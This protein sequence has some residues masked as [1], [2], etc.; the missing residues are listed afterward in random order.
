MY[1]VKRRLYEKFVCKNVGEIGYRS[2][3]DTD[4]LWVSALS[5][6]QTPRYVYVG[7]NNLIENVNLNEHLSFLH[8]NLE[9][10]KLV[11]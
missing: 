6:T 9:K 8:Y 11:D 7:K 1:V 2:S 3:R 10:L 4:G 5:S